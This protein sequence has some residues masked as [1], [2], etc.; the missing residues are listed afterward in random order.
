MTKKNSI[1]VK[2][3]SEN[4]SQEIIF[5]SPQVSLTSVKIIVPKEHYQHFNVEKIESLLKGKFKIEKFIGQSKSGF[6]K[7]IY[8]FLQIVVLGIVPIKDRVRF[9]ERFLSYPKIYFKRYLEKSN[10]DRAERLI[11]FAKKI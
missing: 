11:I 1:S 8:Y 2:T 6:L 9:T 5:E 10:L 3:E 4:N 7:K